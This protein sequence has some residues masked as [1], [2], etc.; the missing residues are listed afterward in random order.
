[1]AQ[2]NKVDSIQHD[3]QSLDLKFK[4]TKM[5]LV[6]SGVSLITGSI[7]NV[8]RTYKDAPDVKNYS[9]VNMFVKATDKYNQN[10]KDLHRISSMFYGFS[11][12]ALIA[13]CFNF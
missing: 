6:I 8:I 2:Q 11:G 3:I 4:R 1:M 7:V 10:Q 12:V 13:I 9:D 5:P